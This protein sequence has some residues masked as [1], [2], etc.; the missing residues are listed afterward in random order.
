M[1]RH[2]IY[3]AYSILNIIIFSFFSISLYQLFCTPYETD[4]F[5]TFSDLLLSHYKYNVFSFTNNF[6]SQNYLHVEN[7][8][9]QLMLN[10]NIV[11]LCISNCLSYDFIY[12]SYY[13]IFQLYI[14]TKVSIYN[15]NLFELLHF[16]CL[17]DFIWIVPNETVLLFFRLW[18]TNIITF[19]CLSIY[20]IY[21][22]EFNLVLIKLQCFCFSSIFIS[23]NELVELPVVF[24]FEETNLNILIKQIYIYY[25]LI[26]Y[27]ICS[28]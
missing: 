18:N 11:T 8:F 5:I 12:Y 22:Y 13:N 24:F 6:A 23:L 21:P 10:L 15:D 19:E 14:F 25:L 7:S 3:T 16:F 20:V 4:F 27:N 17:H 9:L 28:T 26:P 1:Y 2:L